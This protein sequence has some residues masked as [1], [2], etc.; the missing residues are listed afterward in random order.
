MANF[1]FQSGFSTANQ[2]TSIYRGVGMDAIRSFI[3]D[4]GGMLS[5]GLK[6]S[7]DWDSV[8]FELVFTLP[9]SEFMEMP[10]VILSD[11]AHP[12]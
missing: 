2:V 8:P 6:D 12:A 3:E 1:I 10:E 11:M 7:R 5:I 4:V 9:Y